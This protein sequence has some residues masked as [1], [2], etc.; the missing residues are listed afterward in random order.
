MCFVFHINELVFQCILEINKHYQI[1][2]N[3]NKNINAK[4]ESKNLKDKFK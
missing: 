1:N 2:I 3:V 4:F